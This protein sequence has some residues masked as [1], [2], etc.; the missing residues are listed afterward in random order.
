MQYRD[1]LGIAATVIALI[2]YIPYFRDIFA[3]KTKPHAFTW[4]IWGVLTLIAFV[5]QLVDH[6]GP[7][8]WV[9]GFTAFVCLAIAL[10]AALNG[11][12]NIVRL[13]W[14]ALA[15]AAVALLVWYLTRGPLLS[16]ILITVIDNLGFVPTLRKSYH[17]PF[18]ET[19]STFVLSGIKWMLGIF[20]LAHLSVTTALFPFSI[21]VA[22]WLFVIMLL[23]RR[24]Q[25]GHAYAT[26]SLEQREAKRG[27]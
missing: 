12:R 9:T 15:G 21:V 25:L 22:S 19:M 27:S 13:D 23:V 10:L 8:A 1:L 5:G 11:V 26:V 3:R 18:E 4:L 17:R 2:S 7:G 24:A 14:I 16:V 6:A 20:A